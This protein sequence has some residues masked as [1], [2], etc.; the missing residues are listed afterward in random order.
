VHLFSQC[1]LERPLVA[2]DKNYMQT[3]RLTI[4]NLRAIEEWQANV[5]ALS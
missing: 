1:D 2:H 3:H 4:I 5:D